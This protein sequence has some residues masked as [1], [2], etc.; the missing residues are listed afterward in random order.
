MKQHITAKQL[1]KLSDKGLKK[2]RK[3]W[4]PRVGDLFCFFYDDGSI[5]E[6]VVRDCDCTFLDHDYKRK[7]IDTHLFGVR[8][9][10]LLLSIGQMIEFLDRKRTGSINKP[11][12]ESLSDGVSIARDLRVRGVTYLPR[13][14][15]W[16]NMLWELVK[17]ILEN[18]K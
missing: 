14:S 9:M 8:E 6:E 7:T 12:F 5:G 16:C 2:L 10:Y 4:K 15:M 1:N 13:A 17:E 11:W 3:W 18:E